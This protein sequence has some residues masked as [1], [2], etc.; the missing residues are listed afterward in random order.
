MNMIE[1][2]KRGY[3]CVLNARR[4]KSM[5]GEKQMYL[6]RNWTNW[7]ERQSGSRWLRG[8]QRVHLVYAIHLLIVE[9]VS[10]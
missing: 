4:T 7:L 2:W 5:P 9:H 8:W 10:Q 3:M 1:L 6:L